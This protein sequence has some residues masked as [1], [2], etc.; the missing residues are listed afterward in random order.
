M[1]SQ[2]DLASLS[3][4]TSEGD[5]HQHPLPSPG[6]RSLIVV[7]GGHAGVE[8]A[9]A[10]ARLGVP[11]T[12]I[13]LRADLLGEMSCNPAIGGLGKGQI[14][15]EIDALGGLMGRVAD[16]TGLQ[17]RMLNTRKGAA[18]RAP[19]CQSDRLLYRE[20]V[21]AAVATEALITQVE[22]CVSGLLIEPGSHA[23]LGGGAGQESGPWVRGVRLSSGEELRASAVILTTG[24]F[25]RAIMHTG[26]QQAQG[27]RAGEG[28]AD[29]LSADFARL[30]LST[31]RLKTGT[32]PRLVA[33]SIKWDQLELQRGDSAPTPFSWRT[34]RAKFPALEQLPCHITWT[35]PETHTI[36][37][38]NIHLSPM[39]SGRI[40]GVGPRYCP[41]VEDKVMRFADKDRHQVFLEPESLSSDWIY[42][43]GVSTALPPAVQEAFIHTIPGL[44][45]AR[46]Q[47]HGYA[48][49]YD[50]VQ[51]SQ[52]DGHLAVR[53]VPGLYLAGQ[54]N[55]TS[56][57]EEAAAQGLVAGANA[58]LWISERAPLVL[59]RHQ[60]YI[61]VLID[62]LVVTNPT[63]PYRMFT[64]RAEYRLL[65]RQ[66]TA[67]RRLTPLGHE[68]GLVADADHEAFVARQAAVEAARVLCDRHREAGKTLTE[69]LRRPES[70]VAE[71]AARTPALAALELDPELAA[72]LETDIKY[73]GYI[74]N[75]LEEVARLQRQENRAIPPDFNFEEVTG[76]AAEAREKL[77]DLRPRTLGAA[78]RI[79]GLRPPDV[80]LLAVH[81]ER[82]ARLGSS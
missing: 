3:N 70:K 7:G 17:F 29:E 2:P 28:S 55:G 18:V 36:I 44:E 23:H 14:V 69:V 59:M 58:A 8:A 39:Y 45:E 25:L 50:F 24:T 37:A 57:Y 31:G 53:S 27:G 71:V 81:I 76:L 78:S 6:P 1:P 33:G 15:K 32:P 19:R 13:T 60:A 5:V 49:E 38:E 79:E 61:G 74:Q 48:V 63:E 52:L 9:L 47:R 10:A 51:P 67:D 35:R 46:F 42:A 56:G 75:Q 73:E 68:L 54:I 64:S 66:D 12:L 34:D 11:V 20:A 82:H 43:N 30:G 41:A 26:E 65:L 77:C 16:A 80:A 62:D 22:A 40:Q 72:V 21:V 4:L